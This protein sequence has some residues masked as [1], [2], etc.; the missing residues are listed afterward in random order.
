MS[1]G[2][3]SEKLKLTGSDISEDKA[4]W[5]RKMSICHPVTFYF[6]ITHTL[7]ISLKMHWNNTLLQS[8]LEDTT[9][10]SPK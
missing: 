1:Q 4:P 6:I 10:T 7:F 2:T 9:T 5:L 8:Y 3:F